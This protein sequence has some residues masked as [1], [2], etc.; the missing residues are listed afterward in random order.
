[1]GRAL[2]AGS[3]PQWP[4]RSASARC[5]GRAAGPGGPGAPSEDDRPGGNLLGRPRGAAGPRVGGAARVSASPGPLGPGRLPSGAGAR[6]APWAGVFGAPF[7]AH[8]RRGGRGRRGDP[9]GK[10]AR[11]APHARSVCVS[12]WK[13]RGRGRGRGAATARERVLA[14]GPGFSAVSSPPRAPELAIFAHPAAG[15]EVEPGPR[16]FRLAAPGVCVSGRPGRGQGGGP[17]SEVTK[18]GST[19]RTPTVPGPRLSPPCD[20]APRAPAGWPEPS[21]KWSSFSSFAGACSLAVG[22]AVQLRER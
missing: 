18:A 22:G 10:P 7:G 15:G 4:R 16:L 9:A 21:G 2:S 14:A 3:V 8:A 11:P 17:T 19:F 5:R 12:F 6:R 1:M 20:S 13:R